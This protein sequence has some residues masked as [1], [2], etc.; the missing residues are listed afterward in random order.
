MEGIKAIKKEIP[1][2]RT[3]LGLS[4]VSFGLYKPARE[5]LTPC[6]FTTACRRGWIWPS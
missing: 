2:V 4:N 6:S 3:V 5:V 1:G